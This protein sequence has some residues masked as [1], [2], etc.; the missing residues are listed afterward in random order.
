MAK[1]LALALLGLLAAPAALAADVTSTTIEKQK[2]FKN[3]NFPADSAARPPLP[4]FRTLGDA[5][6]KSCTRVGTTIRLAITHKEIPN[7]SSG[8]RGA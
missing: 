6:A 7:V 5:V 4:T 2:I 8:A 3:D 1:L